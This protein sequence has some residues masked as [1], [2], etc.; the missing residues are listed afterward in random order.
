[1]SDRTN[2]RGAKKLADWREKQGLNQ[3]QA[4]DKIGIDLA[5]YNAWENHR[6]RPGLDWAVTIEQVTS[7]DVSIESWTE[8][9][10]RAS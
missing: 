1:M 10:R 2:W 4:A 9:A 8:Q 6:A 3:Q 7:G 5:R